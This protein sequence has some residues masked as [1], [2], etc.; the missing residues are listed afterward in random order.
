MAAPGHG[1]VPCHDASPKA[2]GPLTWQETATLPALMARNR[3]ASAAD[4]SPHE[5]V[6]RSRA[7]KRPASPAAASPGGATRR[8]RSAQQTAQQTP[9]AATAGH[10]DSSVI[11]INRRVCLLPYSSRVKLARV[12]LTRRGLGRSAPVLTLWAAVVAERQGQPWESALTFGQRIAAMF[13]QS[14]GRSLGVLEAAEETPARAARRARERAGTF[15]VA[16]FGTSVMARTDPSSGHALAAAGA[17]VASPAAAASYL[18]RAF[19]D[20]LPAATAALR[21]LAEAVPVQELQQRD[22]A[23]RLYGRIRPAVPLGVA[24]WGAKGAFDLAAV[25]ALAEELRAEKA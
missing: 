14:K 4:A 21:R 6:T 12:R 5:R 22:V 13:A 2:Q 9:P 24:G 15:P 17:G 7:Q 3:A 20:R 8:R 23:Y 18:H 25:D 16:V 10:G 1:Q 19:G 11:R